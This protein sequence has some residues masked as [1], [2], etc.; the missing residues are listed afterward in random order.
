MHDSRR[1]LSK[2]FDGV[3]VQDK[4]QAQSPAPTSEY[5]P[6]GKN[7]IDKEEKIKTRDN[8][9]E[10]G[11]CVEDKPRS[12]K[13]DKCENAEEIPVEVQTNSTYTL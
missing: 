3:S 7:S 13:R 8:L 9:G 10:T 6:N 11:N 12:S 1:K 4:G 5:A 2:Y